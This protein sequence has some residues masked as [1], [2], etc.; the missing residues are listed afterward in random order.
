[1]NNTRSNNIWTV[2]T[3]RKQNGVASSGLPNHRGEANQ[4][5]QDINRGGIQQ[6]CFTCISEFG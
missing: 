1:M 3:G 4:P 2:V 6:V 5:V